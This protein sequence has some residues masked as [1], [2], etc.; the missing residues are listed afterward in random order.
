MVGLRSDPT[1][2][3]LWRL[4][5]Q[6]P[7]Q[8]WAECLC[9]DRLKIN[10]SY[11]RKSAFFKRYAIFANVYL[12]HGIFDVAYNPNKQAGGICGVDF[13]DIFPAVSQNTALMIYE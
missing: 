10:I 8:K 13:T 12:A 9:D 1:V 3:M 7:E 5:H 4:A 11:N 6:Q 2:I